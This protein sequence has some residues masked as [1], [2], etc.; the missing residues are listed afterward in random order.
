MAVK[1]MANDEDAPVYCR[2]AGYRGDDYHCL[3]ASGRT[4]KKHLNLCYVMYIK[5]N[6]DVAAYSH[7][8]YVFQFWQYFLIENGRLKIGWILSAKK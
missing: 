7:I 2:V 1:S 6:R 3:L 8:P 4:K 5:W